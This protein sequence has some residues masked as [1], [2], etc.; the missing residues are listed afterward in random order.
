MGFEEKGKVRRV[1]LQRYV[2][3]ETYR[4]EEN[5]LKLAIAEAKNAIQVFILTFFSIP[6]WSPFST[7]SFYL[8]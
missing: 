8:N 3:E 1:Q 2:E 5:D 6:F 4:K 7:C